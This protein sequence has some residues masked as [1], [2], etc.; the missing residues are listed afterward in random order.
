[1]YRSVRELA[2]SYFH[3]YFMDNGKKTMHDYS[4]PMNLKQFDKLDWRKS[5]KDLWDIPD[6]LDKIKHYLVVPRAQRK[7]FRRADRIEIAAGKLVQWKSMRNKI[8]KVRI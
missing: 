8:K 3:E 4:R 7:T 2:L 6:Q 5:E 1:V